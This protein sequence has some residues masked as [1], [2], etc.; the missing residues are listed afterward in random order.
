M[1]LLDQFW[2]KIIVDNLAHSKHKKENG[3]GDCYV[4][5]CKTMLDEAISF[6]SDWR[7]CHGNVWHSEA[8]W[9]GHCWIEIA[10]GHIVVDDSNGHNVTVM[11]ES[12]YRVGK[13]KDVKRYTREEAR[14]LVL[15]EGNY[16]PWECQ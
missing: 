8:G 9:H 5:G 10:D 6:T 14:N 13:V 12:Y 11:S 15:Q 16:G 3:G 2:G 4:V 1:R 7:L